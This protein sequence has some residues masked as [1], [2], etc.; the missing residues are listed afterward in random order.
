MRSLISNA[1]VMLMR[2]YVFFRK[3]QYIKHKGRKGS[4]KLLH[5]S[6]SFCA[7]YSLFHC[8]FQ[9]FFLFFFVWNCRQFMLE[10]IGRQR[11]G[12][13]NTSNF[14]IFS[15]H[16]FCCALLYWLNIIEM[17]CAMCIIVWFFSTF[18]YTFKSRKE[19]SFILI[20]N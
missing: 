16:G 3:K 15:L 2:N 10:I 8:R 6:D 18:R 17:G 9:Y 19:I 14:N 20:W 5:I 11:K 13:K 4:A 7:M 1:H 12:K